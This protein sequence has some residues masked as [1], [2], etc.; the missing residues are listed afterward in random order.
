MSWLAFNFFKLILKASEKLG[1]IE[2]QFN[3]FNLWLSDLG[4]GLSDQS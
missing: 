2:I 3:P 4:T 1:F